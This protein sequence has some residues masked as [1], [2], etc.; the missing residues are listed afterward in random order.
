MSIGLTEVFDGGALGGGFCGLVEGQCG[1]IDSII[2]KTVI[3]VHESGVEAAA[4]MALT[5]GTTS[6]DIIE[7]DRDPVLVAANLA[8]A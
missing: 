1:T 5:M 3:D 2:Q 6:V 8:A 7:E 4:V